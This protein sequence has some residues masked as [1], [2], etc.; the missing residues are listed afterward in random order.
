MNEIPSPWHAGELAMQQR[1]G[2]VER[3]AG[4]GRM[5]IRD[6]L[7]DQHRQF[8]PVLP[9]VVLGAVDPEGRPWATVR[10][11]TPGF[12]QA[13]DETRLNVTM[14][15]DPS[16]PA[17]RGLEDG[18]AIG[19]L[20]IQL[21]TRRRN[22]LNGTIRRTEA[23]GFAIRVAQSYGNCPQYIQQRA[24]DFTR[25]PALAS[26]SPA[27]TTDRL[28]AASRRVVLGADTFFVASYFDPPGGGRQVDVSHRGGKTGFVRVGDDDVLT[29]PDFRGNMFFNTLGNLLVNPRAGLV[30]IDFDTGDLVQMTGTTEVPTDWA[31]AATFQGAER[32]WRFTPQRVVYR[33]AALPLRLRFM[34][35]GW[36]PHLARTGSWEARSTLPTEP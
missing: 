17:E 32:F 2:V 24:P 13:P 5:V 25:D 34:A 22:R 10:A 6:H 29:V 18:D 26:N 20:G 9:F 14:G 7:I 16:D 35:D 21:E 19:I 11:G 12:L 15:R 23:A 27:V 36:S 33:A 31:E 28:D 8:Y 1:A 30:F 3:M 4:V